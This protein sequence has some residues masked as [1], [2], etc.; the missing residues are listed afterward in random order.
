M[1]QVLRLAASA[2]K[3][4]IVWQEA[5]D[6]N[7]VSLPRSTW[8]QVCEP[9]RCCCRRRRRRCWGLQQGRWCLL[10]LVCVLGRG[11][12]VHDLSSLVH[13]PCRCGSGGVTRQHSRRSS[14][15]RHSSRQRRS[16]RQAR[17][18]CA[19]AAA[20][21]ACP[22]RAACSCSSRRRS[23]RSRCSSSLGATQAW[24]VVQRQRGRR[25]R[26]SCRW[27]RDGEVGQGQATHAGA[28]YACFVASK[29]SAAHAA[30]QGGAMCSIRACAPHPYTHPPAHR[31]QKVTKAGFDAILSAP[32]YLNTGC[33]ASQV[34]PC[35]RT[36]GLPA[37]LC[38]RASAC[39]CT[40]HACV[41]Q[42]GSLPR[43]ATA[44]A[45][46]R[47]PSPP[48]QRS[49]CAAGLAA[50]LRCGSPR[51][52]RHYRAGGVGHTLQRGRRVQGSHWAEVCEAE[53]ARLW[54]IGQAGWR[55]GALRR[56]PPSAL[57]PTCQLHIP[58]R[59]IVSP[60][61][62]PPQQDAVLGGEACSAAASL[63][64]AH[65]LRAAVPPPAE[66]QRAGRG[67]VRVGGVHRRCEL[68]Q[69]GVAARRRRRRAPLVSQ[70]G[71]IT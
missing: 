10:E 1:G 11:L 2:G 67:G 50:V 29:L 69:P 70:G 12:V 18:W 27:G 7:D 21:T 43:G 13:E 16:S 44:R 5:F 56:R 49:P 25:G 33:Y 51:L 32:W 64:R 65:A 35:V 59:P 6:G 54:G 66:G 19:A 68:H 26:R 38:A 8:V 42:A 37:C 9:C 14:G 62:A 53:V 55:L 24:D 23:S 60:F 17:Q 46:A 45:A 34:R 20:A 3:A 36:A 71:C 41:R 57:P 58:A 63:V 31:A 39:E 47:A 52:P 15:Q 61:A 30:L 48:R 40:L 22:R 4:P 28:A